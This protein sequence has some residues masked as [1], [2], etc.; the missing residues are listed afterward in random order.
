M[1]EHTEDKRRLKD[2]WKISKAFITSVEHT[3]NIRQNSLRTSIIGDTAR[4]SHTKDTA[5][6]RYGIYTCRNVCSVAK[7][8][9]TLVFGLV[10]AFSAAA[11][12]TAHVGGS[13]FGN[14]DLASYT[15]VVLRTFAY[16]LV[17]MLGILVIETGQNKM[18][19]C[20]DLATALLA[21]PTEKLD[22][23]RRHRM[24]LPRDI[25]RMPLTQAAAVDAFMSI[26]RVVVA[27]IR[28]MVVAET[29]S[30]LVLTFGS[31]LQL[32]PYVM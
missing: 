6:S 21:L 27:E 26:R 16:V 28:P 15:F 8:I 12:R 18:E 3:K 25:E 19:S 24:S 13:L 23:L 30:A 2:F 9:G 10:V 4:L 22:R 1:V 14:E 29:N 5:E 11:Q 17:T 31:V 32:V 7:R 20:F